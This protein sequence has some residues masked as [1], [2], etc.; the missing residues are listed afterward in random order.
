LPANASDKEYAAWLWSQDP[1]NYTL[2]L[3]GARQVESVR[4]F[5]QKYAGLGG[6]AIYFHTR[7][8]GQDWYTVVYGVY[9]DKAAARRAIER[10]PAELKSS[11]PWVRSFASI[12]A[13]LDRAQ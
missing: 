2:Q 1:S 4:Q 11:S 3:L 5:L 6:K 8:D 12:H 10:L 7:H 13:E 9:S